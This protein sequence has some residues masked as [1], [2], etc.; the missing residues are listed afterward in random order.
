[1]G[2]V[3]LPALF[4]QMLGEPAQVLHFVDG[5]R[6]QLLRR[7]T[8]LGHEG[9]VQILQH[10]RILV[11]DALVEQGLQSRGRGSR[12]RI[13]GLGPGGVLGVSVVR[14]ALLRRVLRAHS[15]RGQVC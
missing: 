9:M 3:G 15:L 2:K 10:H 12:R 7:L 13:R 6:L 5:R 11:T 4:G 8:V 14:D 1:M